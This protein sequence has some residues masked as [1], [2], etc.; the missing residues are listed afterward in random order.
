MDISNSS[1]GRHTMNAPNNAAQLPRRVRWSVPLADV[2]V[3]RWLDL[4]DSISDSVRQLIRESIQ[5][6]G[7]VDVANKP[8]DQLPAAE[9]KTKGEA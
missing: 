7:Y 1:R 3:N 2:S 6:E 8:V 9:S 4:Q 5:R